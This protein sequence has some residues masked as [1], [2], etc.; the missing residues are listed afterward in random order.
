MQFDSFEAIEGQHDATLRHLIRTGDSPERV[1]AAWALG[2]LLGHGSIDAI[3]SISQPDPGVRAHLVVLLAGFREVHAL[4]ALAADDPDPFVREAACCYL[5][6]ISDDHAGEHMASFMEDRLRREVDQATVIGILRELP[7]SWRVLSNDVLSLLLS[8]RSH[9]VRL[10]TV[11]YLGR[12]LPARALLSW[13]E[14]RLAA[15][16]DARVVVRIAKMTR[17]HGVELDVLPAAERVPDA[18]AD[19]LDLLQARE[20]KAQWSSLGA[21]A[22]HSDPRVRIR[23]LRVCGSWHEP[24][25]LEWLS[26]QVT[27]EQDTSETVCASNEGE[28]EKR[29]AFWNTRHEAASRIIALLA[30][31][32]FTGHQFVLPALQRMLSDTEETLTWLLREEEWVEEEGIDPDAEIRRLLCDRVMLLRAIA[33]GEGA[34]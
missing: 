10:E 4:Q 26:A 2:L 32:M 22:L 23:C 20:E 34:L 1:W 29:A 21:L 6:R 9:E 30:D 33:S 8:H 19:I 28:Q 5:I 24:K 15:E 11:E 27:R 25:A 17:S 3:S 13:L 18:A 12:H 14:W 31:P 7:R 16:R